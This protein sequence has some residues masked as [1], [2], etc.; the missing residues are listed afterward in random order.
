MRTRWSLPVKPVCAAPKKNAIP[1]GRRSFL[2]VLEALPKGAVYLISQHIFFKN[3][4]HCLLII[5]DR[6]KVSSLFYLRR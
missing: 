5:G 4:A 6:Y 3:A 1:P 2:Y